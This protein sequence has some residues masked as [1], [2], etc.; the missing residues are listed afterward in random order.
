MILTPEQ[1]QL[2]RLVE[3]RYDLDEVT[4]A[5]TI[6]RNALRLRLRGGGDFVPICCQSGEIVRK[7]ASDLWDEVV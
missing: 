4:S 6:A 7:N 2:L 3:K 1:S 5:E